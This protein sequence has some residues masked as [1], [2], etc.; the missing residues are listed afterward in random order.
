VKPGDPEGREAARKR[1]AAYLDSLGLEPSAPSPCPYLPGRDSRLLFLRPR[2]LTPGLYHL[3]LDLNFRRLGW[4]VYR[5]ECE[6]CAECRQLRL[7]VEDFEPNRSQRRCWRRNADV[8]ATLGPP[9]ATEEKHAVYRR[10]LETR[11]DGEMTGAWDEFQGFLHEAPPFTR[12]VVF[13]LGERFVGAGI[14]DIEPEAVSAVYFYFDP[15]LSDRSPGTFNVLWLLEEC[16]Q[17]GV[18]WLYLGYH[19]AGGRGMAY[20]TDFHPHQILGEDGRWRTES[21]SVPI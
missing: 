7:P 12:E 18:P 10:Y 21:P 14:V 1:L 8:T 6:G 13:R 20:K 17:R 19:V 5:P 16:R 11:H 3:L 4:G 2:Q 15:D 9:E